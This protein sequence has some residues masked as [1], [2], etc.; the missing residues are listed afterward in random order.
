MVDIVKSDYINN[1]RREYSLYVLQSRAIPS[2]ADGLKVSARRVLWTARDGK[3]YKS[4]TLAGLTMPLHPH[5]PPEG[6]VN[7][8]AAPFINNKPLLDGYGAFGTL[9]NPNAF[10]AARYTSV[11]LSEFAKKVVF[12][13]IDIIPMIDNYDS[14]QL[15]PKHFCPHFQRIN[16]RNHG[17][18][19]FPFQISYL[20]FDN[21]TK[22]T[23]IN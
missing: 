9:L 14:T 1:K 22:P 19:L 20:I 21:I 2:L 15:E 8:L 10:G 6:T 23:W 7:A 5:A 18:Q 12:V 11:K 16:S 4:A 3:K 17:F 13:D